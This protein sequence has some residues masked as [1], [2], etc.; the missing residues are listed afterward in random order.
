[1]WEFIKIYLVTFVVFLILEA[2]WLGFIAKNL[3]A[4]EL[5]YIMSPNPNIFATIAFFSNIYIGIYIFCYKSIYRKKRLDLCFIG[6][7]SSWN[8]KLLNLR[9]NK[10]C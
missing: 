2:L 3:Y 1:M 5:G 6:G 8:F 10:S 9:F 7:N 4:K